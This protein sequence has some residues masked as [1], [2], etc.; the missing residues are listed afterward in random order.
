M[1][2][3]DANVL[4]DWLTG[5]PRWHAWSTEQLDRHGMAGGLAVNPLIFAEVAMTF[6]S[7][8]QLDAALPAARFARL[9][10]PYGAAFRAGHA[11]REYRRAGGERR[12]PMPDFYIG[13]H[14][15]VA[16]LPLLTRDVRRYRTYFPDVRLIAPPA[17]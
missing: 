13:A 9:A 7:A 14:A 2:L 17:A 8:E 4:L 10:L 3:V 12:S 16:G 1:V 5:D 15:A 6:S 11:F